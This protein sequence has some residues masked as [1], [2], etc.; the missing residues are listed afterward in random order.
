MA[1]QT[2]RTRFLVLTGSLLL[3]SALACRHK[4]EPQNVLVQRGDD[5]VATGS[6]ATIMDS[7]PGDAILFSGDA[8][9]GGVAGGDYLGAGGKQ[10]ITGRIHGSLR[11]AGG[12]IHVAA[13]VDRNVSIAAG[14]IELD[15]LGVVARN[16]YLFGGDIQVD[17]AVR[18]SLVA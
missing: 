16:A 2:D 5:V 10:A 8:S 6:M 15:S 9:F 13:A 14:R 7:V 12:D 11:A 1:F 4:E 3:A 17:G 18:G